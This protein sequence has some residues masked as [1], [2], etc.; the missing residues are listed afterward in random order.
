MTTQ[1]VNAVRGTFVMLSLFVM[2]TTLSPSI[3][4]AQAQFVVTPLTEKTVAELPSGPLYWQVENFP[5]LAEA[6][7]AAGPMSLAVEAEGKVWLFTLGS[8]GSMTPGG[9]KVVEIGPVPRITAPEYL[10]RINSAI[11]PPGTKTSVHTHPGPETFYVLSGQLT[12]KTPMG[13]STLDVGQ[14]MI[15]MSDMPMEVS[16]SGTTDLHEL[17]MFVVDAT[18]PF[19]SPATLE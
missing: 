9:T 7:A 10:L 16:S 17:I 19:S 11:A 6:E 5:T 18:R 1:V 12:Q 14:T 3:A 13:V 2:W 4:S 15:G 8:Q